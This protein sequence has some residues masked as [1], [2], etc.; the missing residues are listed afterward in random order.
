MLDGIRAKLSFAD[1]RRLDQGV[2]LHHDP[3]G[4]GTN[5]I[6]S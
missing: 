4:V 5:E 6:Q 2:P 3:D 1:Q